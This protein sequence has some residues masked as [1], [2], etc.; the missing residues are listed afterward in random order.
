MS[1]NLA[2]IVLFV[3]NRP[4][5]T[6]QTLEALAQNELASESVLYIYADGPKENANEEVI[7][8]ISETREVVKSKKWCKEVQIIESNINKGLAESVILG[9]TEVI[10]KHEKVIVLE[11]DLIIS[12]YFLK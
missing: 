12:P 8:L 11:D 9:I 7:S 3:Y 4:K 6:R 2:P 10:N 5:H 1:V